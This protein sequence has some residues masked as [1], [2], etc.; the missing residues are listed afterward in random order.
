VII[1]QTPSNTVVFPYITVF[2]WG[3]AL[4]F[5]EGWIFVCCSKIYGGRIEAFAIQ[6][7]MHTVSFI[8]FQ[9]YYIFVNDSI[10]IWFV[11]TVFLIFCVIAFIFIVLLERSNRKKSHQ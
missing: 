4:Y 6:K 2:L 11:A 8:I 10:N 1:I 5:L 3:L 9:F 7:Q